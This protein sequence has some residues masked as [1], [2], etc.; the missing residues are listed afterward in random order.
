MPCFDGSVKR[1]KIDL[2]TRVFRRFATVFSVLCLGP[3]GGNEFDF[4]QFHLSLKPSL[5]PHLPHQKRPEAILVIGLSGKVF[6]YFLIHK[7][8]IK[9]A[10]F[11]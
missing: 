10:L 6:L 8:M 4:L 11:Y 3:Q 7:I 1:Q 2:F 9:Q 5:S